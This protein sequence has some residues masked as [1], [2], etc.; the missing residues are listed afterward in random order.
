MKRLKELDWRNTLSYVVIGAIGLIA[1]GL[2]FGTNGFPGMT[3]QGEVFFTYLAAKNFIRF[4]VFESFFLE[5]VATAPHA[6]AHPVFYTHNPNS[7]TKSLS[8]LLLRLG[9]SDIRWHILISIPTFLVG[10]LYFYHLS[11]RFL[12]RTAGLWVAILSATGYLM[13]LSWSLNFYRVWSWP[14]FLAPLFH[15]TAAGD[16]KDKQSAKLH[17]VLFLVWFA[18]LSV[19]YYS[20]MLFFALVVFALKW[21]GIVKWPWRKLALCWLLVPVPLFAVHQ[22]SIIRAYSFEIWYK[23]WIFTI[24]NRAV[25]I[26][27]RSELQDFYDQ[28]GIVLWGYDK[29]NAI[30]MAMLQFAW[31]RLSFALGWLGAGLTLMGAPVAIGLAVWRSR[32]SRYPNDSQPWDEGIR[33]LGSLAFGVMAIALIGPTDFMLI[34]ITFFFPLVVF[35]AYP[36]MAFLLTLAGQM[37]QVATK[38]ISIGLEGVPPELNKWSR[39]RLLTRVSL[40][41]NKKQAALPPADSWESQKQQLGRL[42][43]QAQLVLL[44]PSP[45]KYDRPKEEVAQLAGLLRL[46]SGG[47]A[48]LMVPLAPPILAL[49]S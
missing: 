41:W 47:L 49:A 45:K 18:L 15:L 23:D 34:S 44:P 3:D 37:A 36:F 40:N 30:S 20:F 22:I 7:I 2:W 35:F 11:R 9:V 28:A 10:Q 12:G 39:L 32:K 38:K 31:Q 21:T 26:P 24:G 13:S 4:G 17:T 48:L 14:L 33:F 27:S 25:G 19:H 8:Y 46:C 5:N 6:A 16:A 29:A 43:V 42:R 1:L